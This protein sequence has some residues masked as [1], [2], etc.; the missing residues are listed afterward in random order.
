MDISPFHVRCRTWTFGVS[1]DFGLV[2]YYQ[3]FMSTAGEK[4]IGK[5]R[6]DCWYTTFSNVLKMLS[7]L[8]MSSNQVRQN[9][10]TL[11]IH[12]TRFFL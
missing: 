4:F 8:A 3:R 7:M 12:V 6:L 2:P 10:H 9:S 11:V 5:G 1:K